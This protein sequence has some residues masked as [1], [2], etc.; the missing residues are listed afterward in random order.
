MKRLRFVTVLFSFFG[1]VWLFAQGAMPPDLAKARDEFSAAAD[2]GDKAALQR[3]LSDD[4]VWVD[5]SGGYRDKKGQLQQSQP[6]R[7]TRTAEAHLYPGGAIIVGTRKGDGIETRSLQV[8]IRQSGQWKLASLQ[9]V[10]IGSQPPIP[11]AAASSALPGNIGSVTDTKAIESAITAL[12]AGNRR[13]D[14][15]N[16][17]ASTTDQFVAVDATGVRSKGDRIKQLSSVS[18]PAPASTAEQSS[19]RIY[20]DLAVTNRLLKNAEGTQVRQTIV[21]VRQGGKWLRAGIITTAVAR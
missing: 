6:G 19:T 12:S 17:A 14:S 2:N 5:R 21:H 3:I 20:G 10:Q 7:A 18:S 11:K 13:G 16:F 1:G 15:K 8:W 9:S 4:L